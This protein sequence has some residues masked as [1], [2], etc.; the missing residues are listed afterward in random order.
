MRSES[1]AS[2]FCVDKIWLVLLSYFGDFYWLPTL[3]LSSASR[4]GWRFSSRCVLRGGGGDTEDEA[5]GRRKGR[6]AGLP[7]V[8]NPT[9]QLARAAL[10]KIYIRAP[11]MWRLSEEHRVKLN[12]ELTPR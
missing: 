1:P 4:S 5:C 10:A 9:R 3:L 12:R 11:S 8:I 2:V 7:L 6:H